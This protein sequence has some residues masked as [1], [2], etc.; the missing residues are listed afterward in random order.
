ML[1]KDIELAPFSIEHRQQCR[2]VAW[3]S[4]FES[5]ESAISIKQLLRL[6]RWQLP[7]QLAAFQNAEEKY[8][9]CNAPVSALTPSA[10]QNNCH[11]I[12]LPK[13]EYANSIY[14]LGSVQAKFHYC[15]STM[16]KWK[17]EYWNTSHS[18][19]R[20]IILICQWLVTRTV[21]TP[22]R[23]ADVEGPQDRRSTK[24]QGLLQKSV[25]F[26]RA[27]GEPAL[28]ELS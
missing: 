17:F 9:N 22:C 23:V 12:N 28:R 15:D 19:W 5:A 26:R 27:F 16:Q 4:A 3:R 11:K 24:G 25:C 20:C 8:N 13:V 14:A 21:F 7:I 2:S 10:M 6:R 18:Y 1:K